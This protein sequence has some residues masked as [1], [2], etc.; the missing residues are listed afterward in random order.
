MNQTTLKF[1]KDIIFPGII[2][3][4]ATVVIIP[5]P[6]IGI[7][8]VMGGLLLTVLKD[9]DIILVAIFSFLIVSSNISDSLRLVSNSVMMF[10]L[11]YLFIKKYG[12][13][14]SNYPG[15][16]RRINHFILFLICLM[17]LSSLFSG[18]MTTDYFLCNPFYIFFV[19]NRRK[20]YFQ[21][22]RGINIFGIRG[23]FNYYILIL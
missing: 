13:Q 14:I 16:P 18:S 8:L 4:L 6:W 5:F 15:L 10:I 19:F 9:E 21:I 2:L 17:V 11:L 3:A 12:I 1:N 20:R 7:G 22:C 23:R